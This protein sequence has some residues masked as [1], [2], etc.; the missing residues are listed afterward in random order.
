[1]VFVVKWRTTSV[2]KW[3]VAWGTVVHG[4]TKNRT[5]VSDWTNVREIYSVEGELIHPKIMNVSSQKSQRKEVSK[6]GYDKYHYKLQVSV[7]MRN[8][9]ETVE[10]VFEWPWEDGSALESEWNDW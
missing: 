4:V 1:M 3:R 2:V 5:W 9:V 8:G 10:L 7:K 6:G